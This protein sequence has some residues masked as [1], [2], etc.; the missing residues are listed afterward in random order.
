VIILGLDQ[1]PIGIAYAYGEPAS[2]PTFGYFKLNDYGDATALLG[3]EV[4]LWFQTFAKS[5][6]AEEIFFEQVLPNRGWNTTT[7]SKQYTVACN[8]ETG[9]RHIGLKHNIRQVKIRSWRTEF[10]AG[11]RPPR[12]ADDESAI[13]KDM[14]VK[15]CARRN[16]FTSDHNVA[17]ACGIWD[18]GCKCADKAYRLSSRVGKRRQQSKQ[19]NERAEI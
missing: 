1:A 18:F 15:E 12:N 16:W 11:M 5:I 3:E 9:A 4:D 10:Y 8:L 19:D 17:E 13:W 7:V 14:A 6:G 2:A